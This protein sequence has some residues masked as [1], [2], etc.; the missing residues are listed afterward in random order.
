MSNVHYKTVPNVEGFYSLNEPAIGSAVH[1]NDSTPKLFQPLTIRDATF[2]NRI[3]VSPMCQYS[4]KDGFASDWH[5]VHLGGFATRGAGAITVEASAVVPEGRISP[6]DLGIWSDEHIAPLKRIVDF[7]HTQGTLIG[8]QLAHAG[9]KAST[10]APWVAMH[11]NGAPTVKN[12]EVPKEL[13]GWPGKVYGPSAIKWSDDYPE[14][15]EITLEGIQTVK[16]AFV[17]AAKRCKE[18]GFDF[19][20]LH[21]AH[22]YLMN[23]FMSP[24]SN[25][26]TD[27]YGGS[28]ANRMRLP[29]EITQAVR[30]V[31]DKPL[32]F[33][34]SATEWAEHELGPEKDES[35]GEYKWWGI[36]QT[37]ILAG[38]LKNAGVDLL[39]VSSGGN[40]SKQKITVGPAYQAPFAEA[41]KKAHP[42]LLVGT[43]GL[44][45]EP[46]QAEDL[47]QQG[48]GDVVYLA[49]E[50]LRRVDFPLIAA[51]ELGAVVKPAN[52]YQLAWRRMLHKADRKSVV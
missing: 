5:L 16:D 34:I 22:G 12:H 45:T 25:H 38:E 19:I 26:R 8:I 2:K 23:E 46:Q 50:L 48:K 51:S 13:G 24:V 6:E 28:L 18:I 9:R 43:V 37:N 30:A 47:L 3:W 10:W 31:W 17:A 44:I 52:Q 33:R 20:E 35:S 32:F 36:E 21:G 41:V 4:S 49:R 29:L 42:D 40:Y 15:T 7:V 27:Q 14:V 1:L 11:L 39:D